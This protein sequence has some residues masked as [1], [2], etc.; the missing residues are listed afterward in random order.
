MFLRD[1]TRRVLAAALMAL[2]AATFLAIV[3]ASTE[4]LALDSSNNPLLRIFPAARD[5]S[6]TPAVATVQ[7]TTANR[8][9]EAEDTRPEEA[10]F[11]V[12]LL[13]VSLKI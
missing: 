3:W 10:A 2:L 6:D 9:E 5:Y 11:N 7:E 13:K 8:T 12:A 4:R 1:S